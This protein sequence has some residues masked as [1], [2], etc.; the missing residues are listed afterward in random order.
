MAGVRAAVTLLGIPL[1]LAGIVTASAP[2]LTTYHI[3]RGDTLTEIAR[4]YHVSV[5]QLVAANDLPG[6]GNLIYAGDSLRIP[7]LTPTA[8]TK[9]V[10]H[11]VGFG[12]TLSEIALRYGVSQRAI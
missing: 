6:N 3:K 10:G 11:R 4:R 5:A 7:T 1:L 9:L 12:D 8:R 2:G